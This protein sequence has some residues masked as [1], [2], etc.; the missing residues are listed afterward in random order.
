[1]KSA[2]LLLPAFALF[3][4][5]CSN[6]EEGKS[7]FNEK[8]ALPASF[9]IG[10]LGLKVITTTINKK[11]RTMSTLYGNDQALNT[12]KEGKPAEP[13]EILALATWKQQDDE[14]WFGAKIPGKLETL[15][16]IK[17][18]AGNGGIAQV[19]YQRYAGDKMAL[20]GDTSANRERIKYIFDQ[21]PS[22]MP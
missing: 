11:Q 6:K 14:R 2:Y 4:S 16:M 17:T 7:I 5:S 20:S 19:N 3:L 15:E 12:A 21:K 10:K 1:M 18:T 8:A 9:N 13:N 22:V